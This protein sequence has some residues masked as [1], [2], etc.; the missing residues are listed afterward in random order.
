MEAPVQGPSR[1]TVSRGPRLGFDS[2]L[3]S[4]VSEEEGSACSYKPLPEEAAWGSEVLSVQGTSGIHAPD[5]TGLETTSSAVSSSTCAGADSTNARKSLPGE[6]LNRTEIFPVHQSPHS[7]PSHHKNS[8]DKNSADAP[9]PQA[10]FSD[11]S[12]DFDDE[13]SGDLMHCCM[14]SRIATYARVPAR[15]R[16]NLN[17]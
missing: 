4:N 14:M 2:S 1:A 7:L 13:L 11:P 8:G 9:E 12:S 5:G 6:I 15:W 3:H 16:A 10:S 17:G